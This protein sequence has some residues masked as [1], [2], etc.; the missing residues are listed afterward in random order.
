MK[1]ILFVLLSTFYLCQFIHSQ[2]VENKGNPIV[3][4][5]SDFHVNLD[6]T[7]KTTGFGLNRAYLGYNYLPGDN[8]SATIIVNIGS[9]EELALG[10]TPRRYAYFKYAFISWSK[11]KFNLSFGITD[12]HL[13]DYQQRFYG[14]RYLYDTFET[15]RGY[16]Y[17]SDLGFSLDYTF[18]DILKADFTLMNGEGYSEPQLDNNLKTSAGLIITPVKQLA[19]RI[20]GDISKPHGI[21]QSTFIG[22]AGFKNELITI[23][24]E[25]TYKFNLDGINSH[26]AWG[27][28]GTGA[29]SISKK[30]EIFVRYD[31]S[32][33][34]TVPGDIIKW[35][36][37]KDGTFII[38]GVQYTLSQNVKL[39]LDYQGTYPFNP[40]THSSDAIF[41]NAL[42]KFKNG[43]NN[44]V[45]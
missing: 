18:N 21:W 43:T 34:V 4:I 20:Y 1:K 17:S 45:Q 2:T 44:R 39:A 16:G 19:F 11:N 32:T 29:I 31:Y 27:I 33:S 24:A 35:N 15:I 9:P 22:F 7:A 25:A 28:S 41:L 23:G 42:F 26:N 10:S 12:T 38:A 6:D 14:K 8:F 37:L 3:E 13:T 5:F 30:A 40:G 36:Y